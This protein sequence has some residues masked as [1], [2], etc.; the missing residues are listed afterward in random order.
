MFCSNQILTVNGDSISN[1]KRTIQFILDIDEKQITDIRGICV[2]DGRLIF[3]WIPKERDKDNK[4]TG[5]FEHDYAMLWQI[6]LLNPLLPPTLDIITT[7]ITNWLNS[8][9]VAK[10]YQTLHEEEQAGYW[11]TPTQGWKVTAIS[12]E[13]EIHGPTFSLFAVEPAWL[14]YLK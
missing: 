11:D 3:G 8:E 9:E 6:T 14:E 13:G 4:P 10:Q 7:I 1:L 5:R 2:K 12:D